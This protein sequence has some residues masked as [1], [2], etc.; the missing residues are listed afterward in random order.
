MVGDKPTAIS[1]KRH[2]LLLHLLKKEGVNVA[3]SRSIT[4]R[5]NREAFPLSYAQQRLW[6]L[7]QLEP[8]SSFY[9]VPAAVRLTGRLNVPALEGALAE[10]VRRHEVLRTTFPAINGQ[11][12][13]VISPAGPFSLPVIDLMELPEAQREACARRIASLEAR[14]PFN[15]NLGPLLRSCI[16]RLGEED[17]I[18]HLNV[19]HIVFDGKSIGIFFHELEV[20]YAAFSTGS[21]SPLPELPVQYA[22]YAAWQREWLQGAMLEKQLAYWKQQLAGAAPALR[23]PTDHPGPQ[24]QSYRGAMKTFALSAEL[25]EAVR[26]F[27]RREK[28]T[29]FMTLL[30]SWMALLFFYSEQDDLVVGTDIASRNRS[31]LE[32]LIGFFGNQLVL[33]ADLSGNPGFRQLLER[34]RVMTLG[35]FA[36][37]DLPFEQLVKELRPKRE[38]G[39]SPLFQVKFMLENEPA[40]PLALSGLELKPVGAEI[41]AAKF[42]LLLT[43]IS[44][45]H[46]IVGSLEYSTDIFEGARITRMLEDLKLLLGYIVKEP[47][48]RLQTFKEQ[49]AEAR[50]QQFM[51]K[52]AQLKRSLHQKHGHTRPKPIRMVKTER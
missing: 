3:G 29:L 33:R 30:A 46:T 2:A 51:E 24:V 21:P 20:L 50:K 15:L 6:F 18:L 45:K 39:R 19:H 32:E 5:R 14:R 40:E 43:M 47:E 4:R 17:H 34:V 1:S 52:E 23:L 8:N 16:L 12:F 10:I 27:S 31:E 48:A 28:V 22:D 41:A 25:S 13:Q 49:L 42:D 37:Q 11:P 44:L 35:A 36:H 9:N 7:N 26:A 38:P